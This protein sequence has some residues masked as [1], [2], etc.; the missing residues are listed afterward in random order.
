MFSS[1]IKYFIIV[2]ILA[3]LIHTNCN[4]QYST[5]RPYKIWLEL[6][7]ET[8]TKSGVL[9]NVTDSSLIITKSLKIKQFPVSNDQ[10]AEYNISTIE[11]IYKRKVNSIGVGASSG[12]FIGAILGLVIALESNSNS[13]GFQIFSDEEIILIS[14]GGFATIGALIG[15]AVGT[16]RYQIPING[17]KERLEKHH[18]KLKKNSLLY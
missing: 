17:K 7:N 1:L 8:K 4:A 6:N 18:E 15:T 13:S 10:L 14:S 12:A 16:A 5:T 2:S 9:Y 11:L 3:G